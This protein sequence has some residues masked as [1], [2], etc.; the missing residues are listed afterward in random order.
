M[1]DVSNLKINERSD[2]EWPN[3]RVTKILNKNW[4]NWFISM[5]EYENYRVV[6]DIER[7]HNFKTAKFLFYKLKKI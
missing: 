2:V 4:D 3:L 1:A 5:G 6:R 7:M